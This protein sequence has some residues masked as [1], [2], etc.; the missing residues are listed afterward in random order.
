METYGFFGERIQ[1]KYCEIYVNGKPITL[2]SFY[3]YL[4]QQREH[5]ILREEEVSE[6]FKRITILTSGGIEEFYV[7]NQKSFEDYLI[8]YQINLMKMQ[9]VK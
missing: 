5:L 2:K 1:L 7:Q 8:T 6:I 4:F 3:E 9:K